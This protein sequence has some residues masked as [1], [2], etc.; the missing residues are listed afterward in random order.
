M[1]GRLQTHAPSLRDVALGPAALGQANHWALSL[2]AFPGCPLLKVSLTEPK[3]TFSFS[4]CPRAEKDT[5]LRLFLKD[6]R[7]EK[8]VLDL[9]SCRTNPP[10]L[11]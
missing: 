5:F 7:K 1:P 6:S 10:E 3:G 4:L 9:R 11:A 2:G 8:N